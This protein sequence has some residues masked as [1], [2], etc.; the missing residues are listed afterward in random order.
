MW[1]ASR[2]PTKPDRK[3]ECYKEVRV[4]CYAECILNFSRLTYR[5]SEQSVRYVNAFCFISI[6]LECMCVQVFLIARLFA[7]HLVD[8]HAV[9]LHLIWWFATIASLFQSNSLFFERWNNR[10]IVYFL[11]FPQFFLP[12]IPFLLNVCMS[13]KIAPKIHNPFIYY[14]F[15]FLGHILGWKWANAVW[16]P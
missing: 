3:T 4:F 1:M 7:I 14:N 2:G 6:C 15:L 12:S 9:L 11:E 16:S 8:M 13:N 5:N 10:C